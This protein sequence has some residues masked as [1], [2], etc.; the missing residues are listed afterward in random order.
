MNY[1]SYEAEQ[2]IKLLEQETKQAKCNG[3]TI[4]NIDHEET[5]KQTKG[6][7]MPG[8]NWSKVVALKTIKVLEPETKQAKNAKRI[9]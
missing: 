3:N 1:I 2:Q 9:Q 5:N 4:S 8:K 6:L 7:L